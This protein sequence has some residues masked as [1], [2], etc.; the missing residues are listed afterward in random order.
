[1]NKGFTL[2]ELMIVIAIVAILAVLA[3]PAYQD[4]TVRARVAEALVGMGSYKSLIA[5]NIAAQARL[6]VSA[7]D[8]M[9]GLVGKTTN[10]EKVECEGKGILKVTTTDRAGAIELLLTPTLGGDSAISWVC[11]VKTGEQQR[12]PAECRD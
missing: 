11:S 2:I 9:S 1:M 7:C 3:L 8:N 12:V 5:E 10:V 4:Y 6:A